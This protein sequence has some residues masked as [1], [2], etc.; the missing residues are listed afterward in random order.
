MRISMEYKIILKDAFKTFTGDQDKVVSPEQTA[1]R[2]GK[3]LPPG[4]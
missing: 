1:A 4:Y 2:C 3:I